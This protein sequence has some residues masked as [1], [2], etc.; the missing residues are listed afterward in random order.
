M[1]LSEFFGYRTLFDRIV[2]P[3]RDDVIRQLVEGLAGAGRVE[4]DSV[5]TIIDALI[6]RESLGS[7]GIGRSIAVPHTRH[8][9]LTEPVG[10]LAIVPGGVDFDSLDRELV[11]VVCL[12]LAPP[13]SPHTHLG[14]LVPPV[15]EE[16]HRNLRNTNF[17]ASLRDARSPTDIDRILESADRG[18]F[19]T[20]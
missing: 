14:R 18:D 13:P 19:H 6:R 12:C 16:L 2:R 4:R 20:T 10:A 11:Y 9:P 8:R 7:T 1:S 15:I 17:V 5:P 3:Q